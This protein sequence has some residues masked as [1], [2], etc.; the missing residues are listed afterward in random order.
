MSDRDELLPAWPNVALLLAS[1]ALVVAL[2]F[3]ALA[4]YLTL[5]VT[6]LNREVALL[7]QAQRTAAVAPPPIAETT[8]AATAPTAPLVAAV[9]P[10]SPAPAPAPTPPAAQLAAPA[11]ASPQQPATVPT[12]QPS[13]NDGAPVQAASAQPP[14]PLPEPTPTYSARVFLPAGSADKAKLDRFAGAV[15]GTGIDVGIT[16][17]PV[18]QPD[19]SSMLYHTSAA[20]AAKKIAAALKT[21][22]PS[23]NFEM[24]ESQTISPNAWNIVIIDLTADALK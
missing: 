21:K 20:G 18:A 15:K 2:M 13:A 23:L 16:E 10:V 22:Y 6:S 4:G 5:E 19:S 17:D 9:P 1:L 24:R 8:E 3:G 12:D 14:S 7:K 11:D